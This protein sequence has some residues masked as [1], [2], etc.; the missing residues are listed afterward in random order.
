MHSAHVQQTPIGVNT[1]H[2]TSLR[3]HPSN[4]EVAYVTA[5]GHAF[6]PSPDRGVFRTTDG[7]V[8]WADKSGNLGTLGTYNIV[9][10][11]GV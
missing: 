8:T 11:C 4:P 7:G 9:K 10:I 2:I 5:L 6:G 3:V 1:Q